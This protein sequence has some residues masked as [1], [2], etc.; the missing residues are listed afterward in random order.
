MGHDHELSGANL[1]G[2]RGQ[3]VFHDRRYRSLVAALPITLR[4]RKHATAR[5]ED[6]FFLATHKDVLEQLLKSAD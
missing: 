1:Y 3:A 2:P 4:L 5:D 6:K